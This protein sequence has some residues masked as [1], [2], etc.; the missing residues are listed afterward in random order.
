MRRGSERRWRAWALAAAAATSLAGNGFARSADDPRGF[1]ELDA[2]LASLGETG[3]RVDLA[4]AALESPVRSDTDARRERFESLARPIDRWLSEPVSAEERLLRLERVARLAQL[5]ER[6][7]ADSLRWPLATG[8]YLAA[9][10]AA[11]LLR[12][13]AA[14]AMGQAALAERFAA[15]AEAFDLLEREASLERSR[16]ASRLLRTSGVET[17][18]VAEEQRRLDADSVRA[19]FLAGWSQVQ[20]ALLAADLAE[21]RV[22]ARQAQSRLLPLLD[23]GSED[24]RPGE[25][26]VDR[27]GDAGFAQ[28]MLGAAIAR[29]TLEG[30][31]EGRAWLDLLGH[32][33]VDREIAAAR[34]AW[35][36]LMLAAADEAETL[37]AMLEQWPRER[38]AEGPLRPEWIRMAAVAAW[39]RAS[40]APRWAAALDAALAASAARGDV[41]GV[42]EMI[43]RLSERTPPS[44]P[45]AMAWS[46]AWSAREQA[47]AR[48]GAAD[49]AEA[50]DRLLR[51]ANLLAAR[52]EASD[53]GAVRFER[54]AAE[55]LLE[56]GLPSEAIAALD[57]R[58]D[59]SPESAWL[60]LVALDRLRSVG[61]IEERAAAQQRWSE[62]GRRFLEQHPD[63][64]RA[65]LVAVRLGGDR[66]DLAALEAFASTRDPQLAREARSAIAERLAFAERDER[67]ALAIALRRL[68]PTAIERGE[69]EVAKDPAARREAFGLVEATLVVED[70]D[71]ARAADL[72]ERLDPAM[73]ARRGIEVT[74]RERD[75]WR[76]HRAELAWLAGD[77]AAAQSDRDAAIN[78]ARNR[79][80]SAWASAAARRWL[81]RVAATW[82]AQ[83]ADAASSELLW[84]AA[85]DVLELAPESDPVVPAASLE[86]MKAAEARWRISGDAGHAR[87]WRSAA[88]RAAREAASAEA[89]LSLA[90]AALALG[91]ANAAVEAS[92]EALQR[93]GRGEPRWRRAKRLQIESLAR[94]DPAQARA[95]LDQLRVLDPQWREG[96]DGEALSVLD[97]QLPP[98][99]PREVAP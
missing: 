75:V 58:K 72:L 71:P 91:D 68:G 36:L 77:A 96:T 64:P 44:S 8:R 81:A 90:E 15:C 17:D 88:E 38:L 74:A 53:P 1:A 23:T 84:R 92:R 57:R 80:D 49:W 7:E 35:E 26:S 61:S 59:E 19:R 85:I 13:G 42:G 5:A 30:S 56:A 55:A 70:P 45:L 14:S 22:A 32:P 46:E 6:D 51:A 9:A 73:L 16:L 41:A 94:I 93:S 39:S 10:S 52:G 21:A 89:S 60:R 3:L 86:A 62:A 20:R 4:I 65:S 11:D 63:H 54:L 2:M 67:L 82:S 97:A 25:V 87:S 66:M 43:A 95:V 28:T 99:P 47:L 79:G 33:N 12:S 50:A 98:A 24:P 76:L 31:A 29:G 78:E 40:R 27:R 34:P 37:Q 18:L 48:G 83:S 69:V